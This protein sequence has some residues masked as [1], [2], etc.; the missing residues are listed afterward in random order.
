MPELLLYLLKAN[1]AL[2]LFYLAYHLVLRKLTFYH[3]NRLFLVFGIVFSTV[4]PLVDLTELFSRHEELAAV[5]IYAV[6]IPAWTPTAIPEQTVFDY[7][8]IP[9]GL[10]WLG[11]GLMLLRLVMQFA[12]LYRIHR[13]SVPASY[14]GV[15]FRKV[16][17]ISEAFSFWKTIYLN[18]A[19]HQSPELESIL[20]HE[21]IHVNGWHTLDVLL[22]ELSTVFYW[23]NPGVW[24]MKK[25]MKENLEFIADQHVVNA[26]V[27]RVAYQ[28]LLLKV[29]GA[30]QPQIA[31]QF[32]FPSLKRRIA[33]MNKMPTSKANRLRLLVVLPLV[34][35]L[36][37]A[38]R[39]ASQDNIT[40]L[41]E[42]ILPGELT[43]NPAYSAEEYEQ[44]LKRNPSVKRVY[45]VPA[46]ESGK[47]NQG[48]RMV[49]ELKSGGLESYRIAYNNE[50]AAAEKKYG[51]LPVKPTSPPMFDDSD[52]PAPP[53]PYNPD[54]DE[55]AKKVAEE[56]KA[57]YARNPQ[58]RKI[59][60]M[61]GNEIRVRLESTEEIYNMADKKSRAAAEKKYG[62]FPS[63]PGAAQVVSRAEFESQKNNAVQQQNGERIFSPTDIGYYQDR[64]NLPVE[65]T[66]FLKRNPTIDKVGWKVHPEKGPQAVVLFL[67]SGTTEMYNLNDQKSLAKAKSKY[68]EFPG[69]L[70]PPP[71]VMIQDTTTKRFSPPLIINREQSSLPDAALYYI[72]GVKSS[73]ASVQKID[74]KTIHSIN[75]VKGETAEETFGKEGTEGV[76]SIITIQNKD[77]RQVREFNKR[78]QLPPP[79]APPAPEAPGT[80]PPPPV[81]GKEAMPPVP[82]APAGEQ[83]PP[84]PPPGK[85]EGPAIPKAGG[86]RLV[87]N[88]DY[89]VYTLW[90]E[91]I[92]KRE[93]EV[94]QQAFKSSG[95]DLK[96][97]EK[98]DGGKINSL[99]IDLASKKNGNNARATHTY[100]AEALKSVRDADN[101]VM[102]IGNKKTGEVRIATTLAPR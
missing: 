90:P 22:A 74:P 18:P 6:V 101:I 30:T 41:A 23:F 100:S 44:F 32:N 3:L 89:V 33:M 71:P 4:Y 76:I 87:E 60:W 69:L 97:T 5:Q 65:Y 40:T 79:P 8:L 54:Q 42:T 75:I 38:F 14:Q 19:Q 55:R 86:A 94:A 34:T 9:V 81:P 72:D 49:F 35:V 20:R 96:F 45:W 63:S 61:S 70:P 15:D 59:E 57:F 77:S 66:N 78:L 10:F 88:E 83:L 82:P 7:W 28:Y 43:Q 29:V 95:F 68:G 36:L 80:P 2:V 12:S 27:D 24:L 98:Y 93:L 21:Q 37:V 56:H 52:L 51:K 53:A 48:D 16:Q 85:Y 47:E 64:N 67:K 102:V 39:S 26:G 99:S 46:E 1:V 11:C 73:K 92:T 58:V 84:P 31:N 25:A 13:A 50:V 91:E 17:G 62:P